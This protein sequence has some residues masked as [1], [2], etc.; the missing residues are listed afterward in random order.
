MT[1]SLLS[2]KKSLFD[3][4][5]Y[6]NKFSIV[7]FMVFGDQLDTYIIDLR[8]D[9]KFSDIEGIAR[10]AEKMLKRKNNLIFSYI[11]M[12]LV[13]Y[14]KKNIFNE[15]DNEVIMKRFQNI[16]TRREQL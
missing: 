15:I 1:F 12:S 7:D 5:F 10:L 2:T 16:K 14:I 4:L 8:N 9:D 13:V 11:Y 6:P 3:L